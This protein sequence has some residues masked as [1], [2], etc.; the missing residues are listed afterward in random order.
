[1]REVDEPAWGERNAITGYYPQYRLSAAM[2]IRGLREGSLSWIALADPN[3]GRVDDFQIATDQR[4]DAFQFKW[5]RYGGTFT[6]NN[7]TRASDSSPSMIK[8][9]A[10]GWKLLQASNP[11]KRV[12]VHLVTNQHPS[13]SDQLP[14]GDPSP[15][16]RHF[17]AFVEQVWRPAHLASSTSEI[18]I[19][20]AWL[21]TW[22]ALRDGSGLIGEEFKAF[23]LDCKL[24]FGQSLPTTE[25]MSSRDAVIFQKDL[26][27]VT[28]KIF[29]AVYDPQ[30]IVR[31][32]RDELLNRLGWRDRF[33]Y[34]NQHSF[35][36]NELLYQPIDDSREALQR[37]L[38]ELDGGYIAVLGTPG[39]GKS[40][41][42][43]QTL[44]YFPQRVIRYY[45]F[46]PDAQSG[47]TRGE[48][49]NFLHDVVRAIEDA[50]FRPGQIINYPDREQLRERLREQLQ[51]LHQDWL[52]TGRKTIILVDG[53][54]HIP[55]EQQPTY[56]LL[57]DLPSPDKVPQGVY[58]VLGSQTDQ[59][60]D[61]PSAVQFAIRQPS[62]RIE[63]GTLSREAVRHIVKGASLADLLS[64]EQMNRVYQL[65]AGHPLALIYLLKQLEAASDSESVELV[66]QNALSYGGRIEEQYHSYWRR[67][68]ED[69]ELA[70]LLGLIA[71][72]RGVI[73]LKWVETWSP[74][75]VIHRL[76]RK[77]AHLFR[78]EDHDRWYFFHNSFRLYLSDHTAHSTPGIFNPVRD[79]A[80]HYEM[81]VRCRQSSD[82]C[83]QWEELYHLPEMFFIKPVARP[84][85]VIPISGE[86]HRA[87][88]VAPPSEGKEEELLK[89]KTVDGLV[90]FGEYTKIKRLEWETPTVIRQSVLSIDAPNTSDG[91]Y[92]FFHGKRFCLIQDYPNLRIRKSHQPLIIW[93]EGHMFDSLG[94]QWLAFNPEL[95]H[96]VGW[97]SD[98]NLLFGWVDEKGQPMVW[99]IWWENGLYQSPPPKFDDDVG[100]GW[101]V[102]GSVKALKVI[103]TQIGNELTQYMRLE[104]SQRVDGQR[105]SKVRSAERMLD[106]KSIAD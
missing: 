97:T 51:L 89:L 44:R 27:H 93:H 102:V 82:V 34:R 53:L 41:L 81:T 86:R 15:A 92:S 85:F 80:Q 73:D 42:L 39:S 38:I 52:A 22:N 17:A 24:D 59:L 61:L 71:R 105:R 36:V 33:E 5:S 45:A 95:A 47:S 19:P 29:D 26:D 70:T 68:D 58:F 72:M 65:S 13:I 84:E 50:G 11:L 62:R 21:V 32:N 88:F 99:S 23:V 67:L 56:S 4:V 103:A 90:I 25:G 28:H 2:V 30:H 96:A 7:L 46:I 74:S 104:E 20:A 100:E 106:I 40:T 31:L 54:D 18:I 6:F 69:D 77:F 55:R 79:R 12:V 91:R 75:A 101:A 37:A 14:V 10:D 66:L 1:M 49:V 48:A 57:R 8:Q 94:S 76:R 98:S 60:D 16:P 87:T 63:M 83:W 43:T 64:Q 78:I 9:L 35:P 3:A